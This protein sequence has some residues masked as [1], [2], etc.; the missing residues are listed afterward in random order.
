MRYVFKWE[1]YA[2]SQPLRFYDR[3]I[4]P[5]LADLIRLFARRMLHC[6][7]NELV[8]VENCT[9]AFNSILNSMI[10]KPSN[11]VVIFN[12]TYGIYKKLLRAKCEESG[13]ELLEETIMFPIQN[14]AELEQKY[15]EKLRELLKADSKSQS[16]KYVF[17]DH[18][19]SNFPFVLPIGKLS[20]LC[21]SMRDDVVFVV[22]GAHTL[23]SVKEFSLEEFPNVDLMFFNC[24]KWLCGPKG[25]GFLFKNKRTTFQIRPAI[26]SHGFGEGFTCE[27][28]WTG[29]K[30]Y[31]S[32]LGNLINFNYLGRI[33]YSYISLI[34]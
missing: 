21:K 8:L 7:P 9:F 27:F 20:D 10:L 26:Q 30:Q 5:L 13:A 3:E 34:I 15:V 19:P 14:Q 4:M 1:A 2:E 28:V 6:E 32:Y 33:I 18:I 17:V 12:T 22:D 29:L 11:K 31:S 25:S 16:I 24:H 23:G